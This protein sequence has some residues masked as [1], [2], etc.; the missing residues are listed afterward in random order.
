MH[1]GRSQRAFIAVVI[2]EIDHELATE[3]PESESHDVLYDASW[4]GDWR[5]DLPAGYRPA[6]P[7]LTGGFDMTRPDT[8]TNRLQ[9][10]WQELTAW[11]QNV[12]RF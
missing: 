7:R 5:W 8:L 2:A 1:A 12:F 10:Y 6:L 9:S 3:N 11:A 4:N